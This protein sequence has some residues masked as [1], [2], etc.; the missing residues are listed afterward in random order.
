MS[1]EKELQPASEQP[2]QPAQQVIV[3]RP[4]I[5]DYMGQAVLTLALAWY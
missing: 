2:E 3:V 4:A 5:R 1:E